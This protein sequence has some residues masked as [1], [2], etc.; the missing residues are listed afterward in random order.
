MKAIAPYSVVVA[1]LPFVALAPVV[2]IGVAFVVYCL[3][4]LVRAPSVKYLPK[5]VWALICIASVPIGGIVYLLVG[6]ADRG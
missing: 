4:D 2:A 5:W 3:V 6:R 1:A